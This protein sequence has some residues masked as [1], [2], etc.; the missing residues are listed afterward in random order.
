MKI[1]EVI[2][3][4]RKEKQMTQEEMAVRLGVTAPAVNKWE[5]GNSFPDISLLA[6]I[7]RLLGI[8]TDI[9]LSYK[10]DLTEGEMNH[11]LICIGD[12]VKNEGFDSA[13]SWT[14]EKIREYP[15]CIPFV[16]RAAQLL[17][18]YRVIYGIA[19]SKEY[20]DKLLDFYLRSLK[21]Q[22]YDIVQEADF[23]LFQFYMM[24]KDYK[25]AQEY[26]DCMPK[27]GINPRQL[28]ANLYLAQGKFQEAYQ[29]YEAMLFESYNYMSGALNGIHSLAIK[30]SNTEK[31][32]QIVSIQ[33]KLAEILEMGKYMEAFPGLELAV[34]KRDKEKVL[35]ILSETIHSAKDLFSFQKSDLY[36]HMTFSNS[37]KENVFIMLQNALENDESL[38]FIKDDARFLKL[39]EELKKIMEAQRN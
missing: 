8:T 30:E 15:N 23:A 14:E 22:D 24:H 26:L 16:F 1:G 36:S 11:I 5:N 33:K 13:F 39:S 31:A 4:Y 18:S 38:D 35:E 27:S 29:L 34:Y 9:L 25:K 28:Q 21:S 3:K 19:P 2:R 10:E 7:A 37:G 12:K 32:E 20:D 17:D 6:P